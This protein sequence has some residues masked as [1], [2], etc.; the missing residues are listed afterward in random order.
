M[1]VKKNTV[2]SI[3]QVLYERGLADKKQRE[4]KAR[5]SGGRLELVDRSGSDDI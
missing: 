1:D 3:K 2:P 5:S 4:Q